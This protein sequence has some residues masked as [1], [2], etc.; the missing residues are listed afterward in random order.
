[1]KRAKI[2]L[3]IGVTGMIAGIGVLLYN[4][5]KAA[6]TS[7]VPNCHDLNVLNR[8]LSYIGGILFMTGVALLIIALIARSL[9]RRNS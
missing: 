4:R 8:R 3:I 1:M 7:C 5:Q 2:L 6:T 9:G